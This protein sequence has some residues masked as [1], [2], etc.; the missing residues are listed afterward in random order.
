VGTADRSR[1]CAN[2]GRGVGTCPALPRVAP[3]LPIGDGQDHGA[4]Q[5]IGREQ[6]ASSR[7][8]RLMRAQPTVERFANKNRIQVQT[9]PRMPWP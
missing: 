9:K 5:R 7:S 2:K 6:A 8:E 3:A 1:R 4:T